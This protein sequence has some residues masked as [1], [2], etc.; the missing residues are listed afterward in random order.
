MKADSAAAKEEHEHALAEMSACLG[1]EAS[2]KEAADRVIKEHGQT[3][4]R[5]RLFF[6][7]SKKHQF[8]FVFGEADVYFCQR[9][10]RRRRWLR[11]KV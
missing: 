1:E 10:R 11:R 5:K 3:L 9:R 7:A 2:A 8:L 6:N 4:I